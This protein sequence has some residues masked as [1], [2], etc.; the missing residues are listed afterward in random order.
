MLSRVS[1][2]AVLC[3][4]QVAAF[5]PHAGLAHRRAAVASAP[6]TRTFA[7][8]FNGEPRPFLPSDLRV[9]THGHLYPPAGPR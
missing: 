2:L 3:L 6:L 5:V 9:H 4:S 7:T 1:L 8:A